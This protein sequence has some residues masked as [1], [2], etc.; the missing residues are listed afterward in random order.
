M[1]KRITIII[2]IITPTTLSFN[3][4]LMGTHHCLSGE[5][6]ICYLYWQDW[7][8]WIGEY[9]KIW[10]VELVEVRVWGRGGLP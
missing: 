5:H 10:G 2:R 4:D 1:E 6:W 8:L 7:Q 3:I 9:L